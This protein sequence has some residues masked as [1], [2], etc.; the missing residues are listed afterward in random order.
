MQVLDQ[1][2]SYS[3]PGQNDG[4]GDS[5]LVTQLGGTDRETKGKWSERNTFGKRKMVEKVSSGNGAQRLT[6]QGHK[7]SCRSGSLGKEDPCSPGVV[8]TGNKVSR[9]TTES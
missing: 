5:E 3:V 7:P 8:E 2:C 6:S 1:G 4:T 9:R